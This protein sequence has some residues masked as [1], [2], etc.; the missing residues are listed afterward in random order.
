M[1]GWLSGILLN[2]LNIFIYDSSYLP[3]KVVFFARGHGF[4]FVAL[5]IHNVS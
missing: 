1:Q 3:W 4:K 2:I 5:F